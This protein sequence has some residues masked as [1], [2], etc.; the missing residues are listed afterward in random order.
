M[1]GASLLLVLYAFSLLSI[2][3]T[4]DWR[5]RHEDNGA[6][7]TTL[8]LSHQRLGIV[9]TRAHDAFVNRHTGE[10]IPYGHH[11]PATALILAAVFTLTGSDTPL[12]ARLTVIFIHLGS[13]ALLTILLAHLFEWPQ[14]LLGGFLMAT[15]PMSTYFGRMVNYEAVCL[16]PIIMQLLGYVRYKQGRGDGIPCVLLGVA[17]GGLVD[18]PSF[19][20]AAAIAFVELVDLVRR[21]SSSLRLLVPLVVTAPCIFVFDLWHLAYA[22]GGLGKFEAVLN[23]NRTLLG[24]DISVVRFVLGQVDTFRRYF[25][26][27][28]LLAMLFILFCLLRPEHPMSRK[29]FASPQAP[30]IR[31]VL[32]SGGL[33]A[34]GY[35]LA[36]PS[37]AHA[38]QYWQFFWLPVVVIALV[39]TWGLLQRLWVE[40]QRPWLRVLRIAVV[41]ELLVSSA[42]WLHWRHTRP[43]DYAIRITAEF[44]EAYLRPSYLHD[45]PGAITR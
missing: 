35:V 39:L 43:E 42:Y 27:V 16:L 6:L 12:V 37:W 33:A 17:L 15:L 40:Q 2:G 4:R 26:D 45:D 34:G 20:T 41:V 28:G 44:R 23:Q 22:A 21:Q 31:R 5:L 1:A 7:H 11:P 13:L 25:T 24:P 29:T 8:A 19:F 32:I 18:W 30:L 38:H 9:R 3:V 36:A 10:V 14:A